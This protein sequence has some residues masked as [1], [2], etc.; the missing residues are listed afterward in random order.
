MLI[1]KFGLSGVS[2]DWQDEVKIL[3]TNL[4]SDPR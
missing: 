1:L 3:H 2:P 4:K